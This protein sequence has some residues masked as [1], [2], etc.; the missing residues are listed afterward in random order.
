MTNKREKFLNTEE[1]DKFAEFLDE[2][3]I[4]AQELIDIEGLDNT[5]QAMFLRLNK[6]RVRRAFAK[7]VVEAKKTSLEGK[8]KKFDKLE[9]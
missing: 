8:L 3:G 4:G 2:M 9:F 1:F 7:K 5:R 6:K